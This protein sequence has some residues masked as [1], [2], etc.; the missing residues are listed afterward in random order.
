MIIAANWGKFKP[1]HF[2]KF[3]PYQFGSG[4]CVAEGG[5][6]PLPIKSV[7]V[8]RHVVEVCVLVVLLASIEVGFGVLVAVRVESGT[9][10]ARCQQFIHWS[11]GI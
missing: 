7:G 2:H 8:A 10:L 6:R 5:H 4:V 11:D 3:N 9:F 1:C